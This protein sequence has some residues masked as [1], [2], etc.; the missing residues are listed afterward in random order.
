[1]SEKDP[2]REIMKSC[3]NLSR[4]ETGVG[5]LEWFNIPLTDLSEWAEAV[6]D[7]EKKNRK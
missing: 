7:M 3:I 4:A 6:L 2:L 5:A 1:L